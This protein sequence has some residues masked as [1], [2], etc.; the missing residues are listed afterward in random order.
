MRHGDGRRSEQAAFPHVPVKGSIAQV[1]SQKS[2]IL[3]T[4]SVMVKKLDWKSSMEDQNMEL[5]EMASH[6]VFVKTKL[7][8][9]KTLS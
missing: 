9:E 4:D 3:R 6:E 1:A 8:L 7:K 2:L 5:A